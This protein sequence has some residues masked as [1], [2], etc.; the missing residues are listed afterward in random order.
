MSLPSYRRIAGATLRLSL[1]ASGGVFALAASAPALAQNARSAARNFDIAVQPLPGAIRQYMQQSGIQVAYPA[2]LAEGVNASAV[3]GEFGSAEALSRLLGGTGLTFRFTGAGTATLERAPQSASGTIQLGPV[4]V[5][6][7]GGDY[8]IP[9]SLTSDPNATEGTG[10]YTI[11][12][13]KGVTRLDL[14]PRETPQSMSVV[15]RQQLDD[16][17]LISVTDAL[18]VVPGIVLSHDDSDRHFLYSRGFSTTIVQV[19]GLRSYDQDASASFLTQVDTVTLD[20]VEVVRG[21]SGLLKGVGNP[22]AA[23]NLVLKRPTSELQGHASVSAGSWNRYRG[24]ADISGPVNEEGTLR[25]RAVAAFESRDN[26]SNYY[27]KEAQ[28][29]YGILEYDLTPDTVVDAGIEYQYSHTDGSTYGAIPLFWS[30]GTRFIAKRSWSPSSK[31]AY[32][33][34]KSRKV[35]VDVKHDFSP[36]WQA[37]LRLTDSRLIRDMLV[38][39]I[40]GAVA[41]NRQTG[42]ATIYNTT[43]TPDRKAKGLDAQVTG[44]VD[45]GGWDADVVA[46][47][48]WTRG[49]LHRTDTTKDEPTTLLADW[50]GEIAPLDDWSGASVVQ[51]RTMERE[52]SAYATARLRP[53][54]GL[55]VILGTNFTTYKLRDV[56]NGTLSRKLDES[57]KFVPYAGVV[58]DFAK[59]LSV[60]ASYAQI[61]SPA[62]VYDANDRV[63]DPVTGD[64]YEAG[65]KGEFLDG[66]LNTSIAGFYIRQNNVAVAVPGETTP[67]GAQAYEG[68]DGV[69]SKG[70]EFEV[71]G[72]ILPGWQVQG[73]YT[74]LHARTAA[75]SRVNTGLPQNQGKLATSYRFHTGTLDGAMIGAN[76]TWQDATHYATSYGTAKQGN[77]GVVGLIGGYEVNDHLS[78]SI[79]L[80]NLFDKTYYDGYG[81]YTSYTYGA[82]RNVLFTARY[83]L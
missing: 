64:N 37:R 36:D 83:K 57:G 77:V 75:G 66:K 17:Q 29:Y 22:S 81:L 61:F 76:L 63:L 25:A 40:Y 5:Q 21:A 23:I 24:E 28:T 38:R 55:S 26:F 8:G 78:L 1:L 11:R 49:V 69:T 31:G 34:S 47:Y 52:S 62:S 7:D 27:H 59:N 60:Y 12:Q 70:I 3:K 72:E 9:A 14:S 2:D 80:N 18:R 43:L 10:S 16:Q 32:L 65:I 42:L 30:D 67:S 68:Q 82:P 33:E 19:D 45:L 44:H 39:Q 46:G 74:Y 54:D 79:V 71:S 50:D 53:L 13:T 56:V 41:P 4:Q 51:R 48:S 15:T 73:G 35:F 58:Y 20:R 6:G